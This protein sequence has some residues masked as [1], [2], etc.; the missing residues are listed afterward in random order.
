MISV[1]IPTK[2]RREDLNNFIESLVKQSSAVDELIIVD[3]S[4]KEKGLQKMAQN[5]LV[6]SPISFKYIHTASGLPYQ[7][8]IGISLLNPKTDYVCFFDDDVVLFEDTISCF[9]SKFIEYKDV[10]AMQGIEYNRKPQNLFGKIVKNIFFIGYEGANS[11]ILL[12][13]ENTFVVKPQRDIPITSFRVGFCMKKRVVDEFKFDEWFTGYA[14]LE[15]FDFSYRVCS[16]YKAIQSPLIRYVHNNSP[17]G[18][19]NSFAVSRMY[20]INRAYIFRKFFSHSILRFF[21]FLWS[22]LGQ[23][24]FNFGK[25]L[26]KSD[27]GYFLGTAAAI[28][29]LMFSSGKGSS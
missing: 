27:P 2:D 26:V 5:V 12:S 19:L 13:G 11:K 23:L 4:V 7:R 6:A 14:F 20:I 16:K 24:I 10:V 15:D 22:L 21:L 28:K 17:V 3:A 25:T 1:I 8:N 18:R 29:E 9:L